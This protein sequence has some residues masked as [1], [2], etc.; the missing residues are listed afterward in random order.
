MAT[1]LRDAGMV[2]SGS[3]MVRQPPRAAPATAQG[4]AVGEEEDAG[5]AGCRG[6]SDAW[7]P[8][9]LYEPVRDGG[10]IGATAGAV[11]R[12][13]GLWPGNGAGGSEYLRPPQRNPG[14][15]GT[16]TTIG[17]S[18]PR[19]RGG[20]GLGGSSGAGG[21]ASGNPTALRARLYAAS[22]VTLSR[23][24]SSVS[25]TALSKPS[26]SIVNSSRGRKPFASP[27]TNTSTL[28]REPA[29][30]RATR[31]VRRWRCS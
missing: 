2:P 31:S 28:L 14:G 30:N 16:R 4:G 27:N 18:K 12:C 19:G 25:Q 10:D 1:T 17:G 7:P 21:S 22:L 9:L 20:S 23:N 6:F 8:S 26:K 24:A 3:L 5:R 11:G 15:R 29:S 13:T